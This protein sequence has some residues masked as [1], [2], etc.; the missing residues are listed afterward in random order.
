MI[1]PDR[2]SVQHLHV[3][4]SNGLDEKLHYLALFSPFFQAD[5]FSLH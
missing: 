4:T 1:I 2:H 5:H 3:V